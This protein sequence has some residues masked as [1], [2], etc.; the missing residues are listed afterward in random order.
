MGYILLK[1]LIKF[2]MIIK[3]DSEKKEIEVTDDPAKNHT[4]KEI[5]DF[6]GGLDL[7]KSYSD[8]DIFYSYCN[9]IKHNA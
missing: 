3:I 2:M 9:N 7:S 8:Y 4:R 5:F 1:D 6:L